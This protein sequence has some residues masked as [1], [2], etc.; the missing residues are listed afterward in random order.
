MWPWVLGYFGTSTLYCVVVI[1]VILLQLQPQY[2]YKYNHTLQL[3]PHERQSFRHAALL[4]C[5]FYR[6]GTLGRILSAMRGVMSRG[7]LLCPCIRA[8]SLSRT[9]APVQWQY[10]IDNFAP[11]NR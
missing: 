11:I 4:C 2:Y 8:P 9:A 6:Y 7:I 1:V 3:Q 5:N 10:Q